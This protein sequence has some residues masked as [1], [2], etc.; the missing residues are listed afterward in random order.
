MGDQQKPTIRTC[1][2]SDGLG[3]GSGGLSFDE[4]ASF[5]ALEN[6][7]VQVEGVNLEILAEPGGRPV[8][9]QLFLDRKVDF[10]VIS[11]PVAIRK[12]DEGVN[13]RILG[14][15]TKF[16]SG[17]GGL[18]AS[19][20]SKIESATDLP[21]ANRIAFHCEPESERLL[22]QRSIIERKYG[23]KWEDLK[24]AEGA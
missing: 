11:L 23:V 2:S 1:T 7:I 12:F 13:I 21:R 19:A 10:G 4:F 3:G 24:L 17:R 5:Y 16:V 15:E 6:G 18:F 22:A 9:N 20:A 8:M 14:R